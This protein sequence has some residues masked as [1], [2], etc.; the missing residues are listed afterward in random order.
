MTIYKYLTPIVGLL[1]CVCIACSDDDSTREPS[2][3]GIEITPRQD[4]YH[5]GDVITCSIAKVAD[6]TGDLR[7]ASYWWYASWWFEDSELRADFEE[8]DA[9][10]TNTSQPITLT[11]AG[12]VTLYFFGRLEYPRWD[13]RK[14]E[15]S[16][17]ITVLE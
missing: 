11:R 14:V 5:V 17:T 15:I 6:G 16:R 3:G 7:A 4:V 1:M 9:A 10:G 12:E 2:F 13:W 8:F